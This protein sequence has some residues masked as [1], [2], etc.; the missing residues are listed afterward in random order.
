[1]STSSQVTLDGARCHGQV[2]RGRDAGRRPLGV[3]AHVV[4]AEAEAAEEEGGDGRPGADG[5]RPRGERGQPRRRGGP[6]LQHARQLALQEQRGRGEDGAGDGD[7][8]T[9]GEEANGGGDGGGHV[10]HR[11]LGR[12]GDGHGGDVEED[13]VVPHGEE[14]PLRHP[15]ARRRGKLL[16]PIHLALSTDRLASCYSLAKNLNQLPDADCCVQR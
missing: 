9:V 10:L 1:M 4:V 5:E 15:L 2:R 14:E 7:V 8:V 16:I 3:A 6:P 13:H 11:Q 12:E